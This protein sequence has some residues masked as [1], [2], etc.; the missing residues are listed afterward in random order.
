MAVVNRNTSIEFIVKPKDDLY[1]EGSLRKLP[2]VSKGDAYPCQMQKSQNFSCLF[3]HYAKHNGLRKDDLIFS[4]V[5]ELLPDQTPETVHLMPQDEIWVEHRDA[6]K[7]KEDTKE[8]VPALSTYAEQFR[9]ML[10]SGMHSDVKFIVGEEKVEIPAHRVVL[11]ARS[12]YFNAMLSEN[13]SMCESRLGIIRTEQH[14]PAVFRRMLEF[15][16]TNFVRDLATAPPGEVIALLMLA[17]EYLLDD[18]RKLCEKVATTI[19]SFDNIGRLLLLSAGHNAS[20]LREACAEFVREHKLELA[21]DVNFRQDIEL[22]PELGLLLFETSLPKRAISGD[23][24]DNAVL[25][26]TSELY[27]NKR[28]R[29]AD[30]N[31]EAEDMMTGLV[32]HTTLT[33]S[34]TATTAAAA[35]DNANTAGVVSTITAVQSLANS[36]FAS[37]LQAHNPNS[38]PPL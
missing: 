22:N 30:Q 32:A 26:G 36:D 8:L 4:F 28:R 24:E 5:D 1:L 34:A 35:A 17:N 31:S 18:L 23:D 7:N 27:G 33:T 3:R 19:I 11:S 10:E 2:R 20:A 37:V 25:F 21:Q 15:I 9:T 12:S 14:E 29:I 38:Q 16:Y 6:K 13:N